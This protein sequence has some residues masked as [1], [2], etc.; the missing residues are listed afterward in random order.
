MNKGDLNS[1]LDNIFKRRLSACIE[2]II[3]TSVDTGIAE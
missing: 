2:T 1:L 3:Y